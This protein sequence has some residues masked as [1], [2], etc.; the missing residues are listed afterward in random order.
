MTVTARRAVTATSCQISIFWERGTMGWGAWE[1]LTQ[2]TP[3][4]ITAPASQTSVEGSAH[5]F[6]LGS[7][8][9]PD[10]GPWSVDVDWG[11][12]T[13][14][15]ALT[16]SSA[17]LLPGK[18]HTYGEEGPAR[19]AGPV[20]RARDST[21]LPVLHSPNRPISACARTGPACCR[22]LAANRAVFT[23]QCT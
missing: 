5:L 9:D 8:S 19:A 10:G 2:S 6:D 15:T 3:P 1:I 21:E 12:G 11:D 4:T 7:F 17:G 16:V 22:Q 14:H 23:R 20:T 18:N 13:S